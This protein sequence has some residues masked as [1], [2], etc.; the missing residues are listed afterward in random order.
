MG[1]GDAAVVDADHCRN[2][3]AHRVHGVMRLVTM[4]RPIAGNVGNEL[5]GGHGADL[6]LLDTLDEVFVAALGLRQLRTFARMAT[7][8]RVT[9]AAGGCE[10]FPAFDVVRRGFGLRQRIC[11]GR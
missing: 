11:R 2:V 10:H 8:I 1:N 7:A 3:V 6:A 5:V 9:K 4:Q